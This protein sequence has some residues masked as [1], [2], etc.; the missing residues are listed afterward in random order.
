MNAHIKQLAM[1]GA[2]GFDTP[3]RLWQLAPITRKGRPMFL[4]G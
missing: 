3:R 1:K 2:K 4:K